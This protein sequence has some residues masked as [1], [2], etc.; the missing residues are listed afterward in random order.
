MIGALA[1]I[2]LEPVRRLLGNREVQP[3]LIGLMTYRIIGGIFLSTL[4]DS[5]AAA[6]VGTIVAV[7]ASSVLKAVPSLATIRPGLPTQYWDEWHNLYATSSLHD[8]WKGVASTV[9]WSIL[10][11]VIGLWRFQRKDILS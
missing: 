11:T 9:V 5:T 8:M 1:L 6:V 3:T 7:V 10:L 4:T 2:L